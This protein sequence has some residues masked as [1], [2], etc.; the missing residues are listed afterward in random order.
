MQALPR[1]YTL[2]LRLA[3]HVLYTLLFFYISLSLYLCHAFLYQRIAR[4]SWNGGRFASQRAA[5]GVP[6]Y[7]ADNGILLS[8]P[9][10]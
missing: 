1:Y 7:S 3:P 8:L 5:T 6:I 4:S 9:L 2:P 10:C